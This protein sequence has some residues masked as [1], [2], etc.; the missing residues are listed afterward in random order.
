MHRGPWDTTGTCACPEGHPKLGW[1]KAGAA[2]TPGVT[3]RSSTVQ[4]EKHRRAGPGG[5]FSPQV[6][7]HSARDIAG[8]RTQQDILVRRHVAQLSGPD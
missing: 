8:I 6:S 5:L 4:A 3:W 7:S 2:H 1:R